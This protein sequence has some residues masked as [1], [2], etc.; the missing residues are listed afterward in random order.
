MK[1]RLALCVLLAAVGACGDNSNECDPGT[2]RNEN[3]VCIGTTACSDGT[4]L[5][6]GKC[7]IDPNACQGGTVLVGGKCVDPGVAVADIEEGA[8]PN[9]LGLIEQSVDPAGEIVLKPEGQHFVIHGK[10]VPFRDAD[11][12]G[13]DD[14]DVDTYFIEVTEPTMLTISADGVNGLAAGFVS[15][16]NVPST[17]PLSD[18]TRFGINL[19]GDMSK[20]Q[21][22]LPVAGTYLVGIGDSRTLLLSG[23]SAGA[24]EGKPAFEYY[25]TVDKSPAPTT[26][27]TVTDGVA[28]STGTRQPGEVKLFTVTLGEGVNNATLGSNS[29]QVQTSVAIVNTH[30]STKKVLGVGDADNAAG[31]PAAVGAVGVRTGDTSI[32]VADSVFD[33]ANSP[34]D[35][36]LVVT[37]GGAGA[38]PTNNMPVSQPATTTD[39]STFY[40][41]VSPDGLLIGLNIAFN[42]PV[43][44]VVVDENFFIF[45][46]FTFDPDFGF[47]F[48]DTFQTYK[49]LMKHATPGR[50]YFLVFDPTLTATSPPATLTA[51]SEYGSVTTPTIV[52]GTPLT[53]QAM[54]VYQSNP[55]TYT[56]AIATDP[57]QVFNAIGTGTGTQTLAYYNP[58]S[59]TFIGRLDT[60]ANT[61]GSFCNDIAVPV[62]T[63]TH[64]QAGQP[65]GR[66]LLDQAAQNSWLVTVNT[67]TVTGTPA[68]DLSFAVQTNVNDLGTAANGTPIN[69]NDKQLTGTG[70]QRFLVRAPNGNRLTINVTPDDVGTNTRFQRL[71]A[72]E[73]ANGALVNNGAV[74]AQDQFLGFQGATGWTAFVVD[75]TGNDGTV[76]TQV[77]DERADHVRDH[78]GDHRVHRRLRDAARR[79]R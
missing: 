21:L 37:A 60:L 17:N 33:Y 27:L 67:A 30:G 42:K 50:Y 16:A 71:N 53:A 23:G 3:G 5:V 34:T 12:D 48:A 44:G 56:P 51:T 10:I 63:T 46:L 68:F 72:D 2:T 62:F 65:R 70:V 58:A 29:P 9:G 49:G 47:G 15:V 76:D 7:E 4:I 38:L 31:D 77:T 20:R 6:D 78:R 11:A 1:S 8:E 40:Y 73:S 14:A 55:F 74:G 28:T 79:S 57:W 22:Y 18:W 54:N 26:A 59:P 43:T 66:I 32:V 52:K 75:K 35:Y 39:F 25:V 24:P 41:D 69:S 61:C 36:S 64:A 13:Q 19:T 45:S